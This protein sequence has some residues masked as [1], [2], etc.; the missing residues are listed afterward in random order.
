MSRLPATYRLAATF[1]VS[2]TLP[3]EL[4]ERAQRAIGAMRV[5]IDLANATGRTLANASDATDGKRVQRLIR[6]LASAHDVRADELSLCTAGPTARQA[7]IEELR[8]FGEELIDALRT[9][10]DTRWSRESEMAS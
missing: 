1:R 4:V 10:L 5:T 3:S 8:V 6:A 9:E 7:S 2:E